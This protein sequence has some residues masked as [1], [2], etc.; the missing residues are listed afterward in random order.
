MSNPLIVKGEDGRPV[1]VGKEEPQIKTAKGEPSRIECPKC[2]QM[3]DYILGEVK[4]GCEA[5]YKYEEDYPDQRPETYDK[6]KEI[7]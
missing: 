5:C 2:H 3:V 7:L 1:F 4:Q 6:S